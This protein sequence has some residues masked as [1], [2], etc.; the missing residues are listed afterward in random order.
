MNSQTQSKLDTPIRR[1]SLVTGPKDR[2]FKQW[3]PLQY[4]GY[5]RFFLTCVRVFRFVGR[6]PTRVRPK[7]EDTSGEAATKN[8]AGH[9]LRLDL[10][11]KSRVK[12]LWHPGYLCNA[13][14]VSSLSLQCAVHSFSIIGNLENNIGYSTFTG[15]LLRFLFLKKRKMIKNNNNNNNMYDFPVHNC[16][17]TQEQYDSRYDSSI[18][19]QGKWPPLSL[20]V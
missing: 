17:Q 7:A 19:R 4:P 12:S 13:T 2:Y 3:R 8:R 11:R 6:G 14:Y 15:L 18:A 9:F 5:Q 20:L 10:N 16:T 1:I